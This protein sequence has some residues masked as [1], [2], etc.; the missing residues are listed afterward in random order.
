MDDGRKLDAGKVFE[1]HQ[2]QIESVARRHALN[3]DD[4]PDIVQQVGMRLITGL[5][6]FRGE[7]KLT[8]WL[9]TITRNTATDFYRRERR[10]KRLA[11]RVANGDL[12]EPIE[13]P[14]QEVER[15]ERHAA[16]HDA[17][18]QL[19]G[20][21]RQAMVDV[22]TES[23][24]LGDRRHGFQARQARQRLREILMRD[25]RIRRQ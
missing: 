8:S 9:H 4:V 10:H 7:A 2:R 21:Q 25:P 19:R 14:D 22:L 18:Q 17:I 5:S 23:D 12:E 15:S 16:L 3:Q 6:S 24:V 1:L 13:D 20:R 11:E